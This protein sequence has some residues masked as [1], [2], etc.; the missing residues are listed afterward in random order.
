MMK[1]PADDSDDEEGEDDLDTCS[2]KVDKVELRNK[3]CGAI[4]GVN[5]PEKKDHGMRLR[6]QVMFSTHSSSGE[7]PTAARSQRHTRPSRSSLRSRHITD[8]PVK[9]K[10]ATHEY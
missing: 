10:P 5:A 2:G 9:G 1:N 4:C 6:S 3:G 8:R 7:R